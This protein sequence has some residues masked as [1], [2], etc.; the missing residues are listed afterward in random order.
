MYAN[1]E[2]GT[3]FDETACVASTLLAVG[4]FGNVRLN[5]R[6]E[7]TTETNRRIWNLPVER[8][9]YHME[10]MQVKYFLNV[11]PE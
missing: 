5:T 8:A 1:P 4:L 6:T 3:P 11:S 10:L 2:V 7:T 9:R